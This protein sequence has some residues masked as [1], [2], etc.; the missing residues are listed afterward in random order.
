VNEANAAITE[1]AEIITELS[2]SLHRQSK[3]AE[4]AE[5]A[6]KPTVDKLAKYEGKTWAGKKLRQVGTGLKYI[7]AGTLAV[8]ALRIAL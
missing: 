8:I 6:L 3:R 7:G 4:A 2:I 1:Q 5:N